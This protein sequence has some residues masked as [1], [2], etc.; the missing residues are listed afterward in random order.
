MPHTFK[1]CSKPSTSSSANACVGKVTKTLKPDRTNR[2]DCGFQ[3]Q[4]CLRVPL[5]DSGPRSRRM[6]GRDWQL[7]EAVPERCSRPKTTTQTT[8][9]TTTTYGDK[10][11]GDGDTGRE[12]GERR[13][14]VHLGGL[15]ELSR[16]RSGRI[17]RN[18]PART[19][20]SSR[21]VKRLSSR[22]SRTGGSTCQRSGRHFGRLRSTTWR[23]TSIS[24]H[25][26]EPG[27]SVEAR[28]LDHPDLHEPETEDLSE[29]RLFAVVL[30]KLVRGCR[31]ARGGRR[32]R[33]ERCCEKLEQCENRAREQRKAGSPR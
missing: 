1:V 11:A 20:I 21:P 28:V 12:S 15:R 8:T 16:A 4:G 32:R 24:R 25:I 5:H 18:R 10:A 17:S 22:Q 19:W 26:N 31:T 2:A 6:K 7:G 9:T 33:G 13:L 30:A 29:E 14:R 3:V 27:R 23:R